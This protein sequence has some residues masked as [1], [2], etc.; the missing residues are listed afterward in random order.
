MRRPTK[1]LSQLE[2][3][4]FKSIAYDAPLNL[5]LGDINILLGANVAGKS[6]IISFFKMLSY[7]TTGAFQQYIAQY[8]TSKRIISCLLPK[9]RYNK[10][11]SGESITSAITLPV[12]RERCAH[13]NDW[14]NHIISLSDQLESE[15]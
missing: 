14:I 6:N 5:R 13:F 9:Y 7:M 2:I 4:G 10:V 12:L 11:R 3:R 1:K 8:G 15:K